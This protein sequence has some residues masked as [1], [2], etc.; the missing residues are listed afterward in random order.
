MRKALD[1][2]KYNIS[3]WFFFKKKKNQ[4]MGYNNV[5]ISFSII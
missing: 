2:F 3:T 1:F 4:T 5:S